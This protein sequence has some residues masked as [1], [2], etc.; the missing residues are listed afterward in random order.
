LRL[1]GYTYCLN[2]PV[3][4]TD[5]TGHDWNEGYSGMIGNIS[6]AVGKSSQPAPQFSPNTI[7]F[8]VSSMGVNLG[9]TSK[10]PTKTQIQIDPLNVVSIDLQ[11]TEENED[12]EAKQTPSI[13]MGPT[14][15]SLVKDQKGNIIG[16]NISIGI[17][18]PVINYK[19]PPEEVVEDI[20]E[21]LDETVEPE[22]N[23]DNGD[24]GGT[25]ESKD[26]N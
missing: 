25:Q 17:G 16:A 20:N 21:L 24:S 5:P 10:E 1:T 14:E 19:K 3:K 13:P 8:S 11:I 18:V 12:S 6:S 15:I 7:G 23:E 9:W 26:E 4:Y 2:N 22:P